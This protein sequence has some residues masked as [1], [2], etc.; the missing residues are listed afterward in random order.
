MKALKQI[1][2]IQTIIFQGE[3]N[4]RSGLFGQE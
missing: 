4:S 1:E 3:R 2:T